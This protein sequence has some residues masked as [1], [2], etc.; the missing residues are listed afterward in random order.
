MDVIEGR[1]WKVLVGDVRDGLRTLPANSVHCCVTSPPYWGLRDYG[2]ASWEGGDSTCDHAGEPMR[3]SANIN[4]NCGTGNDVKNAERRQFYRDQCGKCGAVRIDNQ[5]GLET[6]PEA[7]VASMVEVFEEVRRVLR[8][9]GTCWVNIGDSY[10]R[11]VEK[12]GSGPNGKHDFIPDYGSARKIMA[13]SQVGS[14]D[15]GVGRAERPG[16]RAIAGGLKPKD[17]VGIPWRLAFA[18]QAAGW[19]LR[20]EIIWHKRSPMPESVTDR[21]TKSHEQIFLLTKSER[22]F[23]DQE[24]VREP[25]AAPEVSP[26]E[27]AELLAT[28][29]EHWYPRVTGTPEGKT[30]HGKKAGGFTPP[31]G[32]NIRTVWTL[33]AESFPGAHFATFPSTIPQRAIKAGTSEY[34]CCEDCGVPFQRTGKTPHYPVGWQMGCQC[35]G[36][37]NVPCTVLDPFSGS[38]TTGMVATELGCKYIGCELNPEYAEMSRKR[39]DS[40]KHRDAPKAVTPA[41]GQRGLFE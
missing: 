39:I 16:T 35:I 14:S 26:E 27:Y 6:T 30:K 9:D 23:F 36:A 41:I 11:A 8:P 4:R 13:S 12:G 29:S 28:T 32:R 22:Y 18:L 19:W 3:T 33:S 34:G 10:A 1:N 24:A 2:T 7:F 25:G 17:L 15:G 38:G 5:L 40:W 21:P 37:D 31:G 20:S